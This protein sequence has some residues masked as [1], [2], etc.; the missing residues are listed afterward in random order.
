MLLIVSGVAIVFYNLVNANALGRIYNSLRMLPFL[1]LLMS[2]SFALTWG[3]VYFSSIHASPRA[4]MVIFYLVVASLGYASDG[5]WLYAALCVVGFCLGFVLLPEL[6]PVTGIAGLFSGIC[7]YLYMQL[8][9]EYAIQANLSA[10]QVLALRFYILFFASLIVVF[11]S[12]GVYHI[13]APVHVL[14]TIAAFMLL[15]V[16]NLVPNFCAQKSIILIGANRFSQ[17]IAWTPVFTF[18]VQ[19]VFEG[20]WNGSIFLL[21]LSVSLL[22]ALLAALKNGC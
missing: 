4:A 2:L 14:Q 19:G 8:S 21:C 11:F 7:G 18:L 17:I 13:H 12:K 5:A 1:W 9:G 20:V 16:F 6:T 3:L 15:I 22:L 10:S